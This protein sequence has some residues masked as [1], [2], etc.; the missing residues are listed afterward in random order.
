M[1]GTANAPMPNQDFAEFLATQTAI[2]SP[3]L[4]PEIRLHLAADFNALWAAMELSMARSNPPP[5]WSIAWPGGQALA[6]YLLDQRSV[7]LG[8]SVLDVGCG[9]GVSAIAAA[10]AGASVVAAMDTDPFSRLAVESNA[11]LNGVALTVVE[12]GAKEAGR[13]WDVVLAG[14]L[15]YERFAAAHVTSLLKEHAHAGSR[16]LLGDVGRAHFPRER[17]LELQ[18]YRLPVS[19]N[20]EPEPAGT[21]TVWQ[22]CPE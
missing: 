7:V 21:A 15:W 16:V 5:Y 8:K 22:L 1:E 17:L 10:L 6:R 20:L 2:G 12:P 3:F 9:S 19:A 4:C 14:D 18:R 11:T 13:G